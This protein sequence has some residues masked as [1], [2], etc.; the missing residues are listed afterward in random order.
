MNQFNDFSIQDE[1]LEDQYEEDEIMHPEIP[2]GQDEA[3]VNCNET[4]EEKKLYNSLYSSSS[5]VDLSDSIKAINSIGRHLFKNIT[6][7]KSKTF[8]EQKYFC[9]QNFGDDIDFSLTNMSNLQTPAKET[10]G[11]C[12]NT[13]AKSFNLQYKHLNS[14]RSCQSDKGDSRES[15]LERSVPK[16]NVWNF[17]SSELPMESMG[18]NIVSEK[19]STQPDSQSMLSKHSSSKLNLDSKLKMPKPSW[20]FGMFNR[21]SVKPLSNR[22]SEANEAEASDFEYNKNCMNGRELLS[23]SDTIVDQVTV[24]KSTFCEKE[25]PHETTSTHHDD[26]SSEGESMIGRLTKSERAQKVKKYLEK[27]HRRKWNKHVNYQSRKKVADTR[28]RYKGRFLSSEQA[29]E[30]AQELRLDQKNKL[31]KARIFII[32]VFDKKTKQLRKRIYPNSK[33]LKRYTTQAL[34]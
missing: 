19:L 31:E 18:Q 4:I 6:Q 12:L 32:E 21:K 33:T 20:N 26:K 34:T 8:F 3:P 30:L 27:K 17:C 29:I 11:G 14:Q 24:G 25:I 23:K 16:E 9:L 13:I 22:F 1:Y 28:P 15:S 2:D 10:K 5:S 7:Q